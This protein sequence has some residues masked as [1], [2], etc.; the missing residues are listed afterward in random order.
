MDADACL[1]LVA[2]ELSKQGWSPQQVAGRSPIDHPG[3]VPGVARR[4]HP[5]PARARTRPAG[6][7]DRRFVVLVPRSE[8]D[9]TTASEAVMD[10]VQCLPDVVCRSLMR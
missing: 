4:P 6:T 7:A 5:P 10:L 1:R 8:R 2:V 9:A 3:D